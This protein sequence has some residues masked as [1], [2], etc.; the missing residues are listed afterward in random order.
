MPS[1]CPYA[2]CDK[3]TIVTDACF[4][5]AYVLKGASAASNK[6]RAADLLGKAI[7]HMVIMSVPALMHTAQIFVQ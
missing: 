3:A 4:S 1:P 7:S 5:P 6:Q 2:A